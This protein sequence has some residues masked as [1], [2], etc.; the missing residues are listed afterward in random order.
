MK[1]CSIKDCFS[2]S[3]CENVKLYFVKE[4]WL[5]LVKWKITAILQA[6]YAIEILKTSATEITVGKIWNN[7]DPN[8]LTSYW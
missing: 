3:L 6:Y 4:Q 8:A 1:Y 5:T 7:A 2:T